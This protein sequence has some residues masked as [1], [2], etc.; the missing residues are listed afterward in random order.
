MGSEMCIRDSRILR[1]LSV[2]YSIISVCEY[3]RTMSK[4]AE[5]DS[6]NTQKLG[7]S[8]RSRFSNDDFGTFSLFK[9]TIN[10]VACDF[11]AYI[12]PG[13]ISFNLVKF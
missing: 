6:L 1:A 4:Y 11:R 7:H 3:M 8:V 13:K 9:I 5:A 2:G 12:R 10:L